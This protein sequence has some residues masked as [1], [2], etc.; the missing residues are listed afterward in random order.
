MSIE[1]CPDKN[2]YLEFEI[3]S[4]LINVTSGSESMSMMSG[5]QGV[6]AMSIDSGPR[7]EFKF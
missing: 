3:K 2:A 4:T 5:A 7:S 1:K 6:D